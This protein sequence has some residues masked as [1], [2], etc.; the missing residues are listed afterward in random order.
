M[1]SDVSLRDEEMSDIDRAMNDHMYRHSISNNIN[2]MGCDVWCRTRA[3]GK[4]VT[5]IVA[6]RE[7]D[8]EARGARRVVEAVEAEMREQTGNGLH[9]LCA[10]IR[11]ALAPFR[12][13]T[14]DA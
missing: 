10:A 7:A 6:A 9:V 14:T 2:G 1:S 8:A 12:Q 4:A 13:E 5:P 11:S 3:L